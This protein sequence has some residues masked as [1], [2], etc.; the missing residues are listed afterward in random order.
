MVDENPPVELVCRTAPL[1]HFNDIAR[2]HCHSDMLITPSRSLS[3]CIS[4]TQ[5]SR[6]SLSGCIQQQTGRGQLTRLRPYIPVFDIL[7]SSVTA[8]IKALTKQNGSIYH[9][10][11][12]T[13]KFGNF[14]AFSGD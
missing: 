13:V 1:R 14:C 3:V 4:V 8:V 9:T 7:T 2:H 12:G 11:N 10:F 6:H 5:L